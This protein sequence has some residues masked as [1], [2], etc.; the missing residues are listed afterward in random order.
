MSEKQREKRNQRSRETELQ[1]VK[2]KWFA[3]LDEARRRLRASFLLRWVLANMVGWSIGLYLSAWSLSTPVLCL[4]GAFAG[5]CVGVAQWWALRTPP[6]NPLPVYGEGE[7]I[8]GSMR[9]HN[10]SF[11]RSN[12]S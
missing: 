11:K 9:G 10:N 8:Q 1:S 3:V 7:Q 2:D 6:P 5:I 12:L 4:G